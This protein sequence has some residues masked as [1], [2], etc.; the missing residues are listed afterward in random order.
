M[1]SGVVQRAGAKIGEQGMLF[2]YTMK[3]LLLAGLLE[4]ILYRLV[5][6]LGMHLAKVAEKH[7]WVGTL[8]QVLSSLGF[9]LLNTVALLLFLALLIVLFRKVASTKKDGFALVIIPSTS[10]LVLLTVAFL[11]FPPTML[12]SIVYNVVAFT[13]ISVLTAQYL[14]THASLSQRAFGLCFFLGISGWLYYQTMS[15]TY[16]LIG[17]FTAPPL[18]YEANRAGE[19]LMVLASILVFWAYGW[20]GFFGKN[21]RHRR[22][23]V[24]FAT[25]GGS[26][27]LALFFLDYFLG[28]YDRAMAV[29]VRQAGEGIGWIFQMGMGYSFYLPFALYVMGLL[30][31]SYTVLKL[32]SMSRPAGY[33]VG[34]MFIAGYALQL[35]HLTLMV[36]LGLLLLNLDRRREESEVSDGVAQRPLVALGIPVVGEKGYVNG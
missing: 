19:A 32:V 35:S 14:V 4:L 1:A 12:A 31:W 25:V 30:C 34:L 24:T 10:L 13:V 22:R 11:Q 33:G 21:K 27:F 18:A 5:S 2:E 29:S 26:V 15:T 20:P 16:G 36:V 7:E 3:F 28:L 23:V 6:R 9:I 17:M 8:F